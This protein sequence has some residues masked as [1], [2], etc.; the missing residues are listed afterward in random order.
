[1][2]ALTQTFVTVLL[3]MED[4]QYVSCCIQFILFVF[5]KYKLKFN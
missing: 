4:I 5:K 1:M 3:V 2:G